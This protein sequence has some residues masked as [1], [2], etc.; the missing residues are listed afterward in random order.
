M[1]ATT[2]VTMGLRLF[3]LSDVPA[4]MPARRLWHQAP[5]LMVPAEKLEVACCP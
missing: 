1:N 3:T 2:E 4:L 5:V